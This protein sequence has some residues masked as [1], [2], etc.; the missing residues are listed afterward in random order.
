[1]SLFWCNSLTCLK[2]DDSVSL[3]PSRTSE[4]IGIGPYA[5]SITRLTLP[6]ANKNC[7]YYK[8]SLLAETERPVLAVCLLLMCHTQSVLCTSN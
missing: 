7:I 8:S 5:R 3:L 2:A 6:F 1:M 4:K